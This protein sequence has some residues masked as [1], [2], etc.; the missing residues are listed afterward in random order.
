M[1]EKNSKNIV[2]RA[3]AVLLSITLLSACLVS[4]LYARYTTGA[5]ASDNADIAKF[6]VSFK[7]QGRLFPEGFVLTPGAASG[8]DFNSYSDTDEDLSGVVVI[9]LEG[10][11]EVALQT[12]VKVLFQGNDASG[13]YKEL[14]V[15]KGYYHVDYGEKT[16]Q[17][18]P[19]TEAAHISLDDGSFPNWA[20]ADNSNRFCI[21]VKEDY[22]P[23]TYSVFVKNEASFEPLKADLTVVELNEWFESAY[24]TAFEAMTDFSDEPVYAI[25]WEWK[26]KDK[27]TF[28]SYLDTLLMA[29][30]ALTENG[31]P[32]MTWLGEEKNDKFSAEEKIT[33]DFDVVQTD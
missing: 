14:C 6:G 26:N 27:E 1:K 8:F 29:C 30:A 21:H 18:Y 9:S 17:Y 16:V 19:D 11:A 15:P 7:T 13:K 23:V 3:A 25:T 24:G 20:E 12:S 10:T 2:L 33:F 5:S 4:G 22:Y 28:E 31:E 32:D